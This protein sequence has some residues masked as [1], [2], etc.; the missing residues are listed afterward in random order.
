MV[1]DSYLACQ[2]SES[3]REACLEKLLGV[4][5][6]GRETASNR[7]EALICAGN[8]VI[9]ISEK[10]K[11]TTF[12]RSKAFVTG[13]RDGSHLDELT[14][15]AHP[16]SAFKIN[17]GVG[18]NFGV[19]AVTQRAWSRCSVLGGVTVAWGVARPA[20]RCWRT[21]DWSVWSC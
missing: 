2:L 8:L 12:E 17:L 16:L 18:C 10:V 9:D 14:G 21:A 4:A 20:G 3:E 15:P 7:D 5:E 1:T 6:D 13:A 11:R 19:T